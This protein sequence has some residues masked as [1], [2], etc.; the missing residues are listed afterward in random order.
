M[1]EV[2]IKRMTYTVAVKEILISEQ[3]Y[4]EKTKLFLV[5]LISELLL[6]NFFVINLRKKLTIFDSNDNA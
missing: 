1:N 6:N 4:N 3:I 5:Q 2:Y